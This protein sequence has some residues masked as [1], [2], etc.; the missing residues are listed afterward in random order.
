[1]G[2]KMV[3]FPPLM[4]RG[5]RVAALVWAIER[6]V[7]RLMKWGA[8]SPKLAER[9]A[10]YCST[11]ES[12]GREIRSGSLVVLQR[13]QDSGSVSRGIHRDILSVRGG[14]DEK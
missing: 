10:L 4:S 2:A 7:V 1:M 9:S 5:M 11:R 3:L 12:R 13:L 14:G 8:G 6:R